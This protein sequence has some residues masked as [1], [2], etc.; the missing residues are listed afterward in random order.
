[1]LSHFYYNDFAHTVYLLH[2]LHLL[3]LAELDDF[4]KLDNIDILQIAKYSN[5]IK[6]PSLLL[7]LGVR[8]I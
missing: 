3:Y 8:E 7:T 4:G 2:I 1:M 6:F 5:K